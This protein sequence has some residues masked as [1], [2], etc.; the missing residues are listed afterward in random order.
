MAK[1]K[2]T[3]IFPFLDKSPA[4]AAGVF[5]APG[6][7]VIGD[8]RLGENSN[9]WFNTIIRGDVN[10]VHIGKNT[11][12]Q[13]LSMLHVTEELPLIIGNGVSVGHQATLHACTIEDN[14]LIGMGAIVLDGALI[15]KNSLVAAGS[16]VPPG[17]EYPEGSLIL[18]NPAKVVR[19]LNKDELKKYSS[20]YVSYLETTK[21]YQE[22]EGFN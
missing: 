18:G 6:A 7:K 19:A 21:Q 12:I 10:T 4:L 16:V 5:L 2:E 14:C 9:I 20:H 13:D 8:V 3:Q 15:R 1:I 17:K 11:N 22:T